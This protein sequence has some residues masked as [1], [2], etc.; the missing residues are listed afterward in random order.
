MSDD[1]KRYYADRGVE[2]PSNADMPKGA[3][4]MVKNLE[5]QIDLDEP[6][7]FVWEAVRAT[8]NLPGK[9]VEIHEALLTIEKKLAEANEPSRKSDKD[10]A[11]PT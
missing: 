1:L 11:S 7:A 4:R 5:Q 3:E 2:S 6:E 10:E 9:W 8:A